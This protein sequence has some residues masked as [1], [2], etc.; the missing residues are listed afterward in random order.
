MPAYNHEKYVGAAIESV[1]NQTFTDFEFIIINDGSSDKTE[2][3]IKKYKDPRIKY[4]SQENKGAHNAINRGI[5]LAQAKYISIINSD[6]IYHPERLNILYKNAEKNNSIFL[7]TDI[8]FINKDGRKIENEAKWLRNL[9]L[10]F[11]ECKSLKETLLTGNIAVTTS[12]FF[13]KSN[14]TKEIGNFEPYRYVHDYDF[15]LRALFKY[16]KNFQY[17][18]EKKYI[19][20][21]L[22][23]AN[24]VRESATE[25]N[26]EILKLIMDMT[27]KLVKDGNNKSLLKAALIHIERLNENLF[28]AIRKNDKNN[29][30]LME[31]MSWKITAPLRWFYNLFLKIKP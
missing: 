20:Y 15:I 10:K 31:T 1:L 24:T 7:F 11:S 30:D 4:F 14:I 21:R 6:D 2:S 29:R 8:D 17:I 26:I 12:N 13:F 23:G 25:L 16:E 5:S 9:Q 19:F 28:P 18:I 3:I 27:F 22:H